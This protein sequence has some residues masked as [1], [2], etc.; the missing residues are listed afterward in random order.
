MKKL[1]KHCEFKAAVHCQ[2]PRTEHATVKPDVI[3]CQ[4]QQ[5]FKAMKGKT[6]FD[7]I[8]GLVIK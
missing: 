3:Y 4:R 1:A 7:L 6:D 8:T 2:R 5:Q